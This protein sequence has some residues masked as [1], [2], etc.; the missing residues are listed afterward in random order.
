MRGVL[1]EPKVSI[2][3][4]I[5]NTEKYL[6]ECLDSIYR[7][8]VKELEIICVDDGS[9]DDTPKILE[10]Y[11]KADSRIRILT[12]ENQG[13]SVAR[14]SGMAIATG[15]YIQFLDS[16]DMLEPWALEYA[17]QQMIEKELDV[18]YFD[19][20]TIFESVQLE[21]EKKSYKTYYHRENCYQN[22]QTGCRLF[23]ALT[24]DGAFRP[25]GN[26]Q[27]IR[28]NFLL[29]CKV[30]YIS[31]IVQEDNAFT[32]EIML[33][34][35]RVCHV[36]KPLYIRRVRS[37]SIMTKPL[38]FSNAYGYFRCAMTMEKY[39]FKPNFSE[40]SRCALQIFCQNLVQNMEKIYKNIPEEEKEKIRMIPV[41][42]RGVMLYLCWYSEQATISQKEK[43]KINAECRAM[44]KEK[45]VLVKQNEKIQY[46]NTAYQQQ[47]VA[48]NN[49]L[50]TLE[51]ETDTFVKKLKELSQDREI[52]QR[53][54]SDKQRQYEK[55][56]NK[57]SAYQQQIKKQE[58]VIQKLND[59]LQNEKK[60]FTRN[61][62]EISVDKQ[63]WQNQCSSLEKQVE[64]IRHE[65]MV[66]Q[67]QMTE[68]SK[69]FH[70]LQADFFAMQQSL[71]FRVGRKL[72]WLPRK[73]RDAFFR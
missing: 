1:M 31:G 71:S 60:I 64:E 69:E 34:A 58:G 57:N 63:K 6:T 62:Q 51:N 32:A 15:E 17:V 9:T 8:S 41:E 50:Q 61:Y 11:S 73:I 45:E 30:Q 27:M 23:T 13:V 46:Q 5:F 39:F 55:T 66:Y 53:Q 70:T 18:F 22:V 19:A 37:G 33:H 24:K 2:I 47:L 7:Q 3:I 56:A 38:A 26:L 49:T 20:Q 42:E 48:I 28:R 44:R 52:L 21:E 72:T 54:L 35:Q 65:N 29:Q 43:N 12:Q 4:P 68:Q 67:Q 40:N 36:N 10:R 14:N 59:T 25:N 16:D